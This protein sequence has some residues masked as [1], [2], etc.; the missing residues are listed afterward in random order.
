VAVHTARHTRQFQEWRR[1][2][3]R[4]TGAWNAW[5]AADRHDGTV[6]YRVFVDALADEERTAA[7]LER[8][9]G[10]SQAGDEAANTEPRAGRTTW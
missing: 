7:E 8:V 2:A 3:E 9:V 5:R 1:S 4:V 6:C 10:L